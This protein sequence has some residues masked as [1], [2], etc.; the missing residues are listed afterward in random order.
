[1]STLSKCSVLA[2]SLF[3]LTLGL[4]SGSA[5]AATPLTVAGYGGAL[6]DALN[7]TLWQPAAQ[8]A[9]VELRTDSHD[10]QPAVRLQV[11]SGKPAWDVIHI[12]A[13]D[14]A[15]L[16]RQK[17]LEPLD[18]SVIDANG[19]PER[20]RGKDWIATNSYSVV[21]GWRTSKFQ[22][23]PK[24]WQEFWDVEKFPG[25][26]ALS[27]APDEM[28]EIALL[29]DGVPREALYPLDTERALKSLEKIKPY[30]SVWW[31]SGAQSSQLIKDGEV[32]LIA[33]WSSRADSVVKDHAAVAYTFSDGLLGYGCMAILKGSKNVAAAQKLIAG[34]VSPAIQ[35]RIPAMMGYY[36]PT[37]TLAFE[38]P[39]VTAEQ[40]AQSNMAPVN[41][42][43]Q[44]LMD[45]QWW[46]EH[47]TDVQE[48]YKELI[49]Q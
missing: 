25:R 38:Q 32:D 34:V 41:R 37:N 2:G 3:S 36:G 44:A 5:A 27:V 8:Q 19:V 18:Y 16:S 4:A 35:A 15:A 39:G 20:A 33:I 23:G 28:L 30:V 42:D 47:M 31:T 10:G 14:C 49:A 24:N 45:A 13:N 21:M 29:A 12:G 17:L 43:K 1:M 7:S 6:Q 48:D 26:R 46:G 40:L 22:E 11:Q 9:G